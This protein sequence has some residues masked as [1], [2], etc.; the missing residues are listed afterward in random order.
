MRDKRRLITVI[1]S[2]LALDPSPPFLFNYAIAQK[3]VANV[4]ED[5]TARTRAQFTNKTRGTSGLAKTDRTPPCA[6]EWAAFC[7]RKLNML[8]NHWKTLLG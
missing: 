4:N 5:S 6:Y 7:A 3:V 1:S 2:H 8:L